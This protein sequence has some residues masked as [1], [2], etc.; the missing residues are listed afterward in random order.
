MGGDKKSAAGP[1]KGAAKSSDTAAQAEALRRAAQMGAPFSEACAKQHARLAE[2]GGGLKKHGT[3]LE[4]HGAGP[5][6]KAA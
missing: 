3:G 4:N 2:H 6:S 5:A 1:A